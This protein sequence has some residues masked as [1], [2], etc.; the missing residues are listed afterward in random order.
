MSNA[1][2]AHSSS[3]KKII[4]IAYITINI[5]ICQNILFSHNFQSYCNYY[6]YEKCHHHL[7]ISG[8]I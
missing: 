7:Q 6:Q 8:A 5:A 2:K 1:K 3:I 4:L